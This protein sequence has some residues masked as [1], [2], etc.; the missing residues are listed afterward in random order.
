MDQGPHGVLQEG[1]TMRSTEGREAGIGGQAEQQQPGH[2]LGRPV[3]HHSEQ[4]GDCGASRPGAEG[5]LPC[6]SLVFY[7]W[8]SFSPCSLY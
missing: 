5:G 7:L 8:I 6:D 1:G 4:R 3:G 2:R